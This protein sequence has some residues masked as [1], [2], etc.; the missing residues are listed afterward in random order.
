MILIPESKSFRQEL[1]YKILKIA[2]L[3]LTNPNPKF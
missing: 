1:N 3:R 2:I